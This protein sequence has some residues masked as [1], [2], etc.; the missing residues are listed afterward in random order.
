MPT[1]A[2]PSSSRGQPPI[3]RSRQ[4][5][6]DVTRILR[7]APMT[8]RSRSA[9]CD[10]RRRGRRWSATD[11]SCF[12]EAQH[13]RAR[14]R[15]GNR[16]RRCVLQGSRMRCRLRRCVSRDGRTLQSQGLGRARHGRRGSSLSPELLRCRLRD[17]LPG[18]RAQVPAARGSW[19]NQPCH[20]TRGTLL[21]RTL[22]RSCEKWT[23]P[24]DTNGRSTASRWRL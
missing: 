16:F 12:N 1:R 7:D 22:R 3:N 6:D 4:M 21:P 23:A 11:S 14:S 18:I 9:M 20:Q 10:P 24:A 15:G 2:R 19:A 17:E 5:T 13:H 8:A